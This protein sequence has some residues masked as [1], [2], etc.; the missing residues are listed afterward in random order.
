MKIKVVTLFTMTFATV[1]GLAG[2]GPKLI[3]CPD[4][5]GGPAT[6]KVGRAENGMLYEFGVVAVRYDE[7]TQQETDL[8]DD[9]PSGCC[10][11][12]FC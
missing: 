11:C 7:A 9:V 6:I 12:V 5:S 1:I 10:E 4:N 8:T 2:C 3:D